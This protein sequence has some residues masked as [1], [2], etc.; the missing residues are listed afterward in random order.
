MI[1]V[2]CVYRHSNISIRM[3]SFVSRT[4]RYHKPIPY[5]SYP[6]YRSLPLSILFLLI[7]TSALHSF[8][9]FTF[10]QNLNAPSQKIIVTPNQ[11]IPLKYA[12]P[13]KNN[14]NNISEGRHQPQNS[15]SH[16]RTNKET[17]SHG[18][19]SVVNLGYYCK[20]RSR[21]YE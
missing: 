16:K 7:A 15:E 13:P 8:H 17:N 6:I 10:N 5:L 19:L 9:S 3:P 14:I 11:T 2:S 20:Y 21:Q 4:L 18:K 12:K 1:H